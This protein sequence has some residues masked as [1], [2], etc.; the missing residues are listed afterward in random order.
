MA[1]STATIV[2]A[3]T[4]AAASSAT[5]EINCIIQ[6]A[7]GKIV[8]IL[9]PEDIKQE[10]IG[11]GDAT[12]I[13]TVH[14]NGASSSHNS[15]AG[16]YTQLATS[17]QPQYLSRYNLQ[18]GDSNNTYTVI[19]T[20]NS[21]GGNHQPSFTAIKY[22]T[23]DTVTIK[24]E[25]RYTKYTPHTNTKMKS[26]LH[27][28]HSSPHSNSARRQRKPEKAGKGL[29]HFALKVCEKVK[30]KGVTTYNEVADELVAEELNMNSIDS[31]NCDQKNIRRRVYDALNVLM[32]MDIISKD[33]KEI[34]WIDLP[35]NSAEQC[36]ELERQNE[37]R[38]Q[39][40]QQKYQQLNEL[41]LHQV[42]FKSL[43]ERNREAEQ[44]GNVP[45]TNSS[46]QLPFIIVNTHKSTKINCSVTNDKSEYIFKFDD[47][48][49]MH[50]DAQVLKRM[51]LLGGLDKGECSHEDIER[52][53]SLVPP[54]FEKYIEAYGNGKGLTCD[55]DDDTM[56]GF[57]EL[58]NDSSSHGY[59]RGNGR[60]GG[61]GGSAKTSGGLRDDDD[62]DDEEFLENSDID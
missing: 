45:T 11:V 6:D 41:L 5:S 61:G 44:Q 28:T 26:K 21:V 17:S 31:A 22:E 59:T 50:D 55:S 58:T 39:R 37:A 24:T 42:A 35:S 19:S 9:R 25:E 15:S 27:T 51:G 57:A 49:E 53:K 38:R 16:S 10:R 23:P 56:T 40:I 36:T 7:N 48:F 62:D 8:K 3:T 60:G 33:K 14:L 30:E 4:S 34:R 43:I 54:N 20:Q 18:S 29:R 2:T 13:R 1:H 46:I 47:Q 52:A 12:T 32:A